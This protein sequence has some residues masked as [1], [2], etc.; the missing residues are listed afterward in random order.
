MYVVD[1]G[2]NRWVLRR[3]KAVAHERADLGLVREFRV[4][5]ALEGTSVPHP[6]P[7]AVCED[8]G[9]LG[10]PFYLMDRVE[11][12][13]AIPAPSPLDTDEG[14]ASITVALVE[15]LAALHEVDWRAGGLADLGRPEGF[16]ERQVDRWNRQ[17]T[18]YQGR[19]L[20]G[21]DRVT[22]WLQRQL[23][24]SFSPTLMHGDYHMLNVLIAP[25]APARV[26][27]VLDWETTTIGDPLLDLV[28]FCEIWE[29]FGGADWPDRRAI[30][31][32]YAETRQLELPDDLTYY[33]ALYNFRMAVL[34]EGIYQRSLQDP[35]RPPQDAVGEQALVFAARAGEICA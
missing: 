34:L 33:G 23:P 24:T 13:N 9:V 11:G 10:R 16:H 30:L 25:D 26:V 14:R 15:A 1:R 31:E 29:S 6:A 28:G 3:P 22:R 2:A 8:S 7:V 20:P 19:E 21:I 18:S 5:S 32:R 17:L 35:S 4:L 27:A 12:V